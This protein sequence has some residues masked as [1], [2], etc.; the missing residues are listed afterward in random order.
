VKPRFLVLGSEGQLGRC[1]VRALQDDRSLVGAYSHGELD[2]ADKSAVRDCLRQV[3]SPCTVVNAAAFTAVDRCETEVEM[4]YRVNRDAVEFVAQA[5]LDSGLR[6][7][8][9]STD[10][11][12]D[13]DSESPYAE[14]AAICP[15]SVYGKSKQAGEEIVLGASEDF[16]VVRSSWIFGP[17]RNFVE[18]ILAQAGARRADGD[19]SPLRVVDDQLGSPTYA[20]DLAAGL[21]D[22]HDKGGRGLYHLANRGVASWWD[23]ARAILDQAGEGALRIE[24]VATASLDLPAPRPANSVL[25][26]ER[27]EAL[28]VVLRPWPEALAAY[29]SSPDRRAA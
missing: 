9:I 11:V 12:F 8:H 7:I 28:G 5:C 27:A 18:A 14:D 25:A 16:L 22:L 15:R 3:S 13:G 20:A 26:C 23:F 17:G 24:R 1:L 21:L 10:Y 6:L 4:A 29:L 19:T 2:I